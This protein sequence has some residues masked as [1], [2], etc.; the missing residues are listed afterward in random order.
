MKRKKSKK[1]DKSTLASVVKEMAQPRFANS[2]RTGEEKPPGEDE[3]KAFVG[4]DILLEAVSST[5]RGAL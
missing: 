1:Q 2:T 4:Q 5:R 3:V